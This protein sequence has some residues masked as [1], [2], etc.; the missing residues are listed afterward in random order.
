MPQGCIVLLWQFNGCCYHKSGNVAG[1]RLH[2]E[3][4]NSALSGV[5]HRSV[6]NAVRPEN[7]E[8]LR[9]SLIRLGEMQYA[10]RAHNGAKTAIAE[11]ELLRAG[12]AK[13]C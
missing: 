5:H 6:H 12:N 9:E 1:R 8:R 11:L 13:L 10:E 2:R 4:G 7:P 3:S